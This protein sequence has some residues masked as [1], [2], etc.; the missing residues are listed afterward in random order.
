MFGSVSEGSGSCAQGSLS[1]EP[2]MVRI[3]AGTFWMGTSE[4]QI[5][6][7][8]SEYDLARKWVE[9]G[10]FEREQPQH[11]LTL[12]DYWIGRYPV[13][14]GQYR[15]FVEADGYGDQRIWTAAGWPWQDGRLHPDYWDEEAWTGD[16]RLPVVG[17]SWYEAYAYCRWL[18]EETG[19][20]YRLPTEA[21]WEKAARG[22]DERLWPWGSRFHAAL[23]N[24]RASGLGWAVPVGRYSPA[25]DSPYGCAEM[26]GNVSEWVATRFDV[27]PA[28]SGDGREDPA[29][30]SERVTRGGSWH[31]PVLRARTVS[32][33]MNDLFF[34]DNDLGFRCACSRKGDEVG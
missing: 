29:G 8:A 16:E 30:A 22:T 25:G 20:G 17:V 31:S 5:Q 18:S 2:E 26:V 11:R 28:E 7:L 14:V 19:R 34:A 24:T 23:C 15:A 21:E 13:T 9:K 3:P 10:Y 6:W 4:A 12:D 33:G 1:F 27:Y 32:R